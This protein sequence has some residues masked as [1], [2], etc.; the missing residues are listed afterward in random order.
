[1]SVSV[2]QTVLKTGQAVAAHRPW[3][4]VIVTAETWTVLGSGL[5]GGAWTLLG[6]WGEVGWV[7]LALHESTSGFI[8][9]ASLACP[10]GRFPALGRLHPPAQRLE[11][12]AKKWEPVFCKAPRLVKRLARQAGSDVLHVATGL[13]RARDDANVP[14]SSSPATRSMQFKLR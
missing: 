12:G 13:R 8:G 4:R 14:Q 2:L 6:L 9:V 1:M 7:H 3:P 10:E 11:R 5:A